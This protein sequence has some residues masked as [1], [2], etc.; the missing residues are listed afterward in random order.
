MQADSKF[1][2]GYDPWLSTV[3]L[4]Q[5]FGEGIISVLDSSAE[6]NV[7]SFVSNGQWRI[8]NSN[9]IR[10]IQLRNMLGSRTIGSQ[11]AVLWSNEQRVNIGVIWESIRRR[12]VNFRWLPLIWNKFQ[13]PSCSFITW[14]ACRD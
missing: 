9:D 11:D 5:L 13:I 10:A 6:A 1:N 12:G 8:S 14:L 7:G 2:F 3:P 4:A